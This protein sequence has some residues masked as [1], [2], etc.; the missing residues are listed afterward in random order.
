MGLSSC[1]RMS[2]CEPARTRSPISIRPA[3]ATHSTPD[4]SAAY[5]KARAPR[6][7]FVVLSFAWHGYRETL[8]QALRMMYGLGPLILIWLFLLFVCDESRRVREASA[9]TQMINNGKQ[10]GLAAHE[11]HDKYKRLPADIR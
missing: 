10:I 7:A 3:A 9:R 1:R 6:I 4:T 11:T 2:R 8:P 5:C